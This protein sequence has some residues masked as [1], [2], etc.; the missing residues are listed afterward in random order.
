MKKLDDWLDGILVAAVCVASVS[1]VLSAA[2]A[3]FG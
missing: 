2:L 1:I 3:A